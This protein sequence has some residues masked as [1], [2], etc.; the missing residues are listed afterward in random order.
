VID[1]AGTTAHWISPVV[2]PWF[3]DSAEDSVEIW[4]ADKEGI[5][6]RS[7]W[8][9]GAGEVKRNAVV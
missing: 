3:V 8:A 9:F 2:D 7:D 6:L 5:M 4:L 1:L